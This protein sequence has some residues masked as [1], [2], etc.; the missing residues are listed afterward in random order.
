MGL[1]IRRSAWHCEQHRG[2]FGDRCL[3]YAEQLHQHL[4]ARRT[5]EGRLQEAVGHVVEQLV[6][7]PEHE[8]GRPGHDEQVSVRN[9]LVDLEYVPGLMMSS[10]LVITSTGLVIASRSVRRM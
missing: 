4:S 6:L 10:S 3:L 8:V 9:V 7:I 2:V 5:L 1:N